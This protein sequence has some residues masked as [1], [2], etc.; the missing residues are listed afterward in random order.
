MEK[1][2]PF[3]IGLIIILVRSAPR[4]SLSSTRRKGVIQLGDPWTR[5]SGRAC[6]SRFRSSKPSCVSTRVLDNIGKGRRGLDQRQ[7]AI[8]LDNYARWRIIDPLA[9]LRIVRTIPGAQARLDDVVLPVARPGWSAQPDRGRLE[10]TQRYHG[11]RD[12]P[13][14]PDI[15]K[16]VWY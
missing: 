7:K 16:R 12:P 11:R 1:R 10:Q 2:F 4:A 5:C 6:I 13:R 3:T 14:R 9:V 8:V 15:M